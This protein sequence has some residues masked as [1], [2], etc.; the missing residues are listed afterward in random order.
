MTD[1]FRPISITIE[2]IIATKAGHSAQAL[3]KS[4]S[5]RSTFSKAHMRVVF[6]AGVKFR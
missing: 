5:S 4:I 6:I 3:L 1:S 2:Q